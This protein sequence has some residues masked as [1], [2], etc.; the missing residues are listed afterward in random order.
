M[1]CRLTCQNFTPKC[2]GEAIVNE[3]IRWLL[4]WCGCA[5]Q[6]ECSEPKLK[7]FCCKRHNDDDNNE[8]QYFYV[9]H[10]FCDKYS[11]QVK[12]HLYDIRLED[13][14]SKKLM[15]QILSSMLHVDDNQQQSKMKKGDFVYLIKE[16][17]RKRSIFSLPPTFQ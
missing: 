14:E 13:C 16:K 4:V 11:I 9:E 5:V 6:R 2:I 17:G 12:G 15:V 1:R 7:I 8:A 3:Y 10:V